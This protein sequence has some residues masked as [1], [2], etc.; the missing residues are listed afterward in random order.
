MRKLRLTYNNL[1]D[2]I[3]ESVKRAVL[4][5]MISPIIW[6]FTTIENTI[7]ILQDNEFKLSDAY[8]RANGMDQALTGWSD[9]HTYFLSTTRSKSSHEGYSINLKKKSDIGAVRIE[10]DGNKLN[11]IAHGKASNFHGKRDA[12]YNDGTSIK[13]WY[14]Q[15][16]VDKTFSLEDIPNDNARGNNE[17]EDT[18][19]YHKETIDNASKYIRRIDVLIYTKTDEMQEL[20]ELCESYN[21]PCF[22]YDDE[23][24]FNMQNDNYFD[25]ERLF[26]KRLQ[27]VMDKIENATGGFSPYYVFDDVIDV[28][29]EDSSE[30]GTLV[31]LSGKW[32]IYD[33]NSKWVSQEWYDNKDELM[34]EFGFNYYE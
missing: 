31:E 21:I 20:E 28:Y 10:L 25:E 5:E 26:Q 16:F 32:N 6:H 30:G 13:G 33:E 23:Q 29:N 2:I 24:S 12:R 9:K 18:V 34:G 14:T 8:E 1:A 11:H 15:K 4:T 7:S 17:K 19:W 3:T 27:E 22:F